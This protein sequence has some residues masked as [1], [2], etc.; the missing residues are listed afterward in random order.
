M[1]NKLSTFVEKALIFTNETVLVT[2][3]C[4]MIDS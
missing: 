2:G 4:G 1:K 3:P